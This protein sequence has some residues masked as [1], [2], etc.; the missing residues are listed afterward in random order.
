MVYWFNRSTEAKYAHVYRNDLLFRLG[1][2]CSDLHGS[3][4]IKYKKFSLKEKLEPSGIKPKLDPCRQ[5][6]C[7]KHFSSPDAKQTASAMDQPRLAPS[8]TSPNKRI[9]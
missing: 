7:P 2:C 4:Y 9:I 1:N 5:K 8:R 6:S 3:T